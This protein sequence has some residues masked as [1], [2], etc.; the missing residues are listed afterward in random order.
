LLDNSGLVLPLLVDVL[1]RLGQQFRRDSSSER[2]PELGLDEQPLV[3]TD[4]SIAPEGL[5]GLFG[6]QIQAGHLV[7]EHRSAVK[8]FRFAGFSLLLQCSGF[9]AQLISLHSPSL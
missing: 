3:Y 8:N 5:P 4:I 7:Y 2:Q 9:T 1:L 6:L